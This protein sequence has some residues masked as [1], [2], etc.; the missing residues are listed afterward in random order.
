M[1]GVT[2]LAEKLTAKRWTP[3][4]VE[5]YLGPIKRCCVSNAAE[6]DVRAAAA[7]GGSVS[8]LLLDAL[9]S[10][11][12][13]AAL[14]ARTV[15]D[16]GH[17]RLRYEL[18]TTPEEVLAARGST[19]VLGDF[20]RDALPLIE[21]HAGRVAV[22][23]LPCEATALAHHP[24]LAEKVAL[25]ISLFCGHATRPE[26]I[27]HLTAR[28][29]EQAG[30]PLSALRFRSGHWRGVLTATFEN[31]TKMERPFSAYGRSQNLYYA[32]AR[33]CLF[34]GDHFGYDADVCA[35]DLWSAEF[36]DDPTKHTALVVKTDRGAA[37]VAAAEASGVLACHDVRPSVVLDGQRRAAPFHHNVT[38]RSK[39]GRRL[40][41][42]IPDRGQ[43][44]S[45]HE[46]RAAR[47]VLKNAQATETVEGLE[48][49]LSRPKWYHTF[50]LY[51]LKGLESLPTR[52]REE[53]GPGT[54]RF[55]VIAATVWGNRGAEAMLETSVGRLRDRVQDA[56]FVV[57]SY[58]PSTDA[59]L[60][61]D[62]RVRVRSSTPKHLVL[63]LFPFSLVLGL[64]RLLGLGGAV[65]RIMPASVRDLYGC[66]ALIDL[67]G[68]SFIDGR[69]KF[70]PFNL[71]TIWPA[72]LLGV[73]VFKLSQ[74]LGPFAHPA[75]KLASKML[76]RCR[77]VVPRG[78]GTLEHLRAAGFP[79]QLTFPAP[80]VAF[81]FEQRDALSTEGADEVASLL[82]GVARARAGSAH[83]L[84]LCP[85]A[86]IAGKAAKEG[87]DYIGFLAG[88]VGGL[89]TDGAA[90][91]LFPNATRAAVP[92]KLRNNDLPVIAQV[93]ERVSKQTGVSETQGA[94]LLAVK[95]DVNAAEIRELVSACDAVAVS[96]FH[97][98]VGALT[99]T[100]PVLVLGWSHKYAEVMQQFD[101]AEWVFDYAEHDAQAFLGRFRELYERREAVTSR[102]AEELPAVKTASVAQFDEVLARL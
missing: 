55:A 64:F 8:A 42:K 71:L 32:V 47:L 75:N 22:V 3:Q 88:I 5:A 91:V 97:A 92:D 95:G 73:P 90:V 72:M 93:V 41:I 4:E 34:C 69:E 9:T 37:A 101:L 26:L 17:A 15:V 40:G 1:G 80:D 7:S 82:G 18:A 87:W 100:V 35:G 102:I 68:V 6:Q 94:R 83:V 11:A 49:A 85:S 98:M 67:A 63:V 99:A 48:R 24:Q 77:M 70:L 2:G 38:A 65:A 86:V 28:L 36:K 21:A 96:R 16:E 25:V 31:G 84:G 46:Y 12:A 45:W 39:A 13:D 54:R 57:Y 59:D 66:D 30:S 58:L 81:G 52:L 33:K 51:L 10:G 89:L 61:S 27:D 44:V 79:A 78:D 23:C 62:P 56:E 50:K 53:G 14:V 20:A 29:A 74:A 19:Y 76:W 43:A 60:I